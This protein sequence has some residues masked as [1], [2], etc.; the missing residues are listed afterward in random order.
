[1]DVRLFI[2]L[3]LL[4]S[5]MCSAATVRVE[6]SAELRS[7]SPQLDPVPSLSGYFQFDD[8]ASH[9]GLYY[10]GVGQYHYSDPSEIGLQS[11]L[12]S[13]TASQGLVIVNHEA[14]PP[15][16]N[17]YFGTPAYQYLVSIGSPSYPTPA[18]EVEIQPGPIVP[19]DYGEVAILPVHYPTVYFPLMRLSLSSRMNNNPFIDDSLLPPS[20]DMVDDAT[21]TLYFRRYGV[22]NSA[23]SLVYGLITETATYQVTSL[24]TIPEP[25]AIALL[26]GTMPLWLLRCGRR[27]NY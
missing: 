27:T 24:R 22:Y 17:N 13:I 20:L 26:V 19:Y 3:S 10:N 25:T 8:A 14:R 4:S 23:G 15:G 5:T 18:P 7:S 6:F 11:S 1:M 9:R 16:G 12:G 21:L 2:A